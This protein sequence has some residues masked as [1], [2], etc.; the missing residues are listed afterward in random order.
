MTFRLYI[1]KN[2][3]LQS[4]TFQSVPVNLSAGLWE[5]Q[6][7]KKVQS[8]WLQRLGKGQSASQTEL[9]AKLLDTI[10]V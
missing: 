6:T 8:Q 5:S 1:K 3:L 4:S 7:A 9:K 2:L 10:S